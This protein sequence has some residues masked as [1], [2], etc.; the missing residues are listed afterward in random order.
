MCAALVP[1]R[2]PISP[3]SA[4]SLPASA[5][6]NSFD[7]SPSITVSVKCFPFPRSICLNLLSPKSAKIDIAVDFPGPC[8]PK[9]IGI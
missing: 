2:I 8:L 3:T 6:T 5:K 9:K 7:A 4:T 1:L